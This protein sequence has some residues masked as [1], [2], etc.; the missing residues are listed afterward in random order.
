MD[1]LCGAT[2]DTE[3]AI[4][5]FREVLTVRVNADTRRKLQKLEQKGE[6]I[7]MVYIFHNVRQIGFI[8][9]VHHVAGIIILGQRDFF[10]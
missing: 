4:D 6:L 9:F 5:Y 7:R 1:D 3:K 8:Y 2:R 10:F